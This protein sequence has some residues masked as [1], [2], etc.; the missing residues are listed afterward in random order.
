[1]GRLTVRDQRRV[2]PGTSASGPCRLVMRRAPLPIPSACERLL[3]YRQ[4]NPR[5]ESTSMAIDTV[6][7]DDASPVLPLPE[8]PATAPPPRVELVLEPQP[9]APITV[10]IIGYGYWGPNVVRNFAEVPGSKVV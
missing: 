8:R 3:G 9:A 7:P 4:T 6:A 2:S 5:E 1:P 10:G